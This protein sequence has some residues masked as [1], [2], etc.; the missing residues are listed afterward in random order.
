MRACPSLSLSLSPGPIVRRPTLRRAGRVDRASPARK[1][2]QVVVN[3]NSSTTKTIKVCGVTSPEDAKLAS[4]GGAN[5]IGMILWPKAP[6]SVSL[7]TARAIA[8]ESR[9]HGS[10]AVGVFVDESAQTIASVCDAVG[11]TYAQLHGDQARAS[12]NDLPDHLGVIYVVHADSN[13]AI[14][15]AL[16]TRTGT[17][18]GTGTG[19]GT[20][21]RERGAPDWYLVDSMKGGSGE[22]F[23]W[24]AVQ[25]PTGSKRGWLLAGGLTDENVAAAIRTTR[26]DGV[27]VSSGVCD[28]TKLKKDP[29]KVEAYIRGATQAFAQLDT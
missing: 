13:G 24:D 11:I 19:T 7:E 12:F 14:R 27:D 18:D 25:P 8:E 1:T 23:D 21:A 16:P 2:T 4:S 5:L 20:G 29:R 26:C 22:K 15:T 17:G 6:R 3:A 10:E 28:E 9:R